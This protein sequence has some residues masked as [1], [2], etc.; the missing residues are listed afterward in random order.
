MPSSRP[1]E[2]YLGYMDGCVYLDFNN[3]GDGR[4][5]L[6]RISFDGYG[7]NELGEHSIPLDKNDS[8]TF[9][10]IIQKDI[11][12]QSLLLTIV[13][14]AIRLNKKLIWTDALEEYNLA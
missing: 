13:K 2:Y 12:E 10:E 11:K 6:I 1:A 5:C 4:I 9:K 7:C 8:R 14:R 3:Y